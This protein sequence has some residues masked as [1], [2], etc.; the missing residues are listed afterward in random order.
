MIQGYKHRIETPQE[1]RMVQA[2]VVC[3]ETLIWT[4]IEEEKVIGNT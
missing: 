3:A 2:E 4:K 1:M